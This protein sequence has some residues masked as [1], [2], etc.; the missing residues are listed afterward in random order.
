MSSTESHV[1]YNLN[2]P[3]GG[4]LCDCSVMVE[5]VHLLTS[6]WSGSLLR[7]FD[8]CIMHAT[9]CHHCNAMYIIMMVVASLFSDSLEVQ[10]LYRPR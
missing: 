6:S 7:Y 5:L 9:G 3:N 10:D 8:G 2:V 4:A 1:A